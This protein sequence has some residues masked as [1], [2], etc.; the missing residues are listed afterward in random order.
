MKSRR[1]VNS[2]VRHLARTEMSPRLLRNIRLAQP[3]G[4]S[5][6][7][8]LGVW[9]WWRMFLWLPAEK[10]KFDSDEAWFFLLMLAPGLCLVVAGSLQAAYRWLWPAVLTFVAGAVAT[11][12]GL[13]VWFL[14]GY[15]GHGSSL[16]V[17]YLIVVYLAIAASVVNAIVEL[18]LRF[19]NTGAEQ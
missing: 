7:L 19:S 2:G 13:G 12:I 1:R 18:V 9:I 17:V 3:I 14:F 16:P 10:R 11:Y 15:T 5:S 8:L 4:G 6:V